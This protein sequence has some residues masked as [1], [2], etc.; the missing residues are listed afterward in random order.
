MVVDDALRAASWSLLLL[1]LLVG[2][3]EPEQRE[4]RPPLPNNIVGLNLARLHQPRYI[5]AAAEVVNANGGSWGYVTILL[6]T[7]DRDSAVADY[8]LQQVLDRCFESRLQPI[9]RVG[10]RFD[11][12]HRR[13]GAAH[14]RR[15]VPAGAL[16]FERVTLAEPDRLDRARQ[17]AES[18]AASGAA[19]VDVPVYARY[20]ERFL[21]AFEESERFK[22]VNA[23]LNLSN[24]TPACR[25]CRTPSSSW[26][27]FGQLAPSVLERLPAWA[28]NSYQ[29]DGVGRGH[30]LHPSGYQAELE[31][32]GRDMPVIITESGVLRRRNEDEEARF[33]VEAYADWR[34]DP[35]IVAATPLLW[36]PDVGRSLDV[37]V[38]RERR[39]HQRT[40]PAYRR[41]REL[42][43]V[44]G[45]P[46]VVPPLP[47]TARVISVGRQAAPGADFLPEPLPAGGLSESSATALDAGGVAGVESLDRAILRRWS[48][49]NRVREG[50]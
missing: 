30:P 41:L 50:W 27:S 33:F 35:R 12:E 47:N 2:A 42:P 43:R 16:L 1:P 6:T 37:H 5:W 10:T 36:D 26:P 7:Q 34:D 21:D 25:R 3:A 11:V 45:S 39:R 29:V 9:V 23:P 48:R 20:L 28:S 31:A 18:R 46:D 14:A 4:D 15:S 13:L 32:I 40:A 22:V 44:A 19:T 49:A 8:M 38:R 17:R 24:A